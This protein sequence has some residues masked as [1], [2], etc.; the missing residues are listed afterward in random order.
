MEKSKSNVSLLILP[1]KKSPDLVVSLCI[2][3]TCSRHCLTQLKHSQERSTC[4]L[5]HKHAERSALAYAVYEHINNKLMGS[6]LESFK[7][8]VSRVD[9]EYQNGQFIICWGTMGSIS[10]LRRTIVG[11]ISMLAP[12]KVFPKYVEN[13]RLLGGV[14]KRSEFNTCVAEMIL[15]IKKSISIVAVGKLNIDSSKV[16]AIVKI[17]PDKLPR[18]EIPSAKDM[19]KIEIKP[20]Y[21]NEY[22]VVK[23]SG[24]AS[25]IVADYI[26]S[27]LAGMT[28]IIDSDGVIVL[29][30]SFDAKRPVI[31][32]LARIKDYV[33]KKYE[34]LGDEFYL[35]LAYI[36][37]SKYHM[38]C[39]TL[40]KII[41]GKPTP[42]SM[43]EIISK[44][45]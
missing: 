17:L 39:V 19:S 31:K 8:R 14:G 5:E 22:P 28:T 12:A 35:S 16:D 44:A 40:K 25:I 11:A 9:C 10:T 24:I 34:K 23:V 2:P 32:E 13:M 18:Q 26:E 33:A 3:F 20:G 37:I 15:A 41:K 30:K 45:L 6:P 21:K 1:S 43:V 7:L 42:K 27:K 38:D 29:N 4:A 36:A